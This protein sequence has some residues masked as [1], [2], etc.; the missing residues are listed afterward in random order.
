MNH[1]ILVNC[2]F[3][4][5]TRNDENTTDTILITRRLISVLEGDVRI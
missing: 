1:K 2:D 3:W 5:K 4:K